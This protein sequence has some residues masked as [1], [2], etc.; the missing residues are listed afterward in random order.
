MTQHAIRWAL[1]SVC[2][3]F[4][5]LPIPTLAEEA[6]SDP[7]PEPD[8]ETRLV[9][10]ADASPSQGEPTGKQGDVQERGVPR[11]GPGGAA[12]PQLEGGVFEGK[13]LRAQ[14]GYHFEPQ[15]GGTAMLKRNTGTGPGIQL[16]CRCAGGKGTCYMTVE[17]NWALC[18]AKT[19]SGDCEMRASTG[20]MPP[21]LRIQ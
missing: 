16:S 10:V 8:C 5:S 15:A 2:L 19:C 7:G 20:V 21:G 17:G 1:L 9:V 18:S 3:V 14:P 6:T 12:S 13:R 4:G 11:M